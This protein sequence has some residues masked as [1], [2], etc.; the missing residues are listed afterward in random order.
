MVVS[1]KPTVFQV[2]KSIQHHIKEVKLPYNIR[3]DDGFSRSRD[4]LTAKRKNLVKQGWGNK[5]NACRHLTDEDAKLFE[6]DDFG[7]CSPQAL[8]RTL[9]WF[10]S[11]SFGFRARYESRKLCWGTNS[12]FTRT[13]ASSEQS[14]L[15]TAVRWKFTGPYWEITDRL[16][17]QIERVL[18]CYRP[19]N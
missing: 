2:H 7:C 13:F 12:L 19:V 6:A 1:M 5:P 3:K 14:K 10:L 15:K 8:Q 4:I 11:M 16:L 17:S 18:A 9:W